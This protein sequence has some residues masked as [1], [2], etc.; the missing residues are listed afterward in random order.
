M[1]SEKTQH[2]KKGAR[3][4]EEEEGERGEGN[5]YTQVV[6]SRSSGE[7]VKPETKNK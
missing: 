4:I 2:N 1:G 3:E 5:R 6:G 7:G